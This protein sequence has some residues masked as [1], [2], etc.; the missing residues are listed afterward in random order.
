M[1]RMCFV[2]T[3]SIST[4]PRSTRPDSGTREGRHLLGR[5]LLHLLVRLHL[6]A[7]CRRQDV[8]CHVD[9]QHTCRYWSQEGPSDTRQLHR[10]IR[11]ALLLRH[12]VGCFG[13]S[14]WV[15]LVFGGRPSWSP[16]SYWLE[17]HVL[18]LHCVDTTGPQTIAILVMRV[19]DAG[20][21]TAPALWA[22]SPGPLSYTLWSYRRPYTWHWGVPVP[23]GRPL[24]QTF[25]PRSAICHTCIIPTRVRHGS[26]HSL[27]PVPTAPHAL[28]HC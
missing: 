18:S 28:I 12:G 27:P 13:G 8:A 3:L 23:I 16:A 22:N 26:H 14:Y 11:V 9:S 2:S 5:Q 20:R 1:G 6:P 24:R 17:V 15:H 21:A 10:H 19:V 7:D 25:T 4:F